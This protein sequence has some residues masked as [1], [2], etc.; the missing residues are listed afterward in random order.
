MANKLKTLASRVLIDWLD[1]RAKWW[2][3][4]YNR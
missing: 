3:A 1:E 4:E 2:R